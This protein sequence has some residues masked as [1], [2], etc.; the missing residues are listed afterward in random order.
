MPLNAVFLCSLL[1]IQFQSNFLPDKQQVMISPSSFR[2]VLRPISHGK[3]KSL[4]HAHPTFCTFLML[5]NES[6]RKNLSYL[7]HHSESLYAFLFSLLIFSAM[8]LM[9][10]CIPLNRMTGHTVWGTTPAFES[11]VSALIQSLHYSLSLP[12]RSLCYRFLS[13]RTDWCC[14][15]FLLVCR[16]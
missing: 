12:L 15:H 9:T 5:C 4:E 13:M 14:S 10:L 2:Q 16:K 8:S 3:D 1:Q 7:T 11:S 6:V